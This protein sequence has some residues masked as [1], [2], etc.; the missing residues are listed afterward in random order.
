MHD[1]QK[2]ENTRLVLQRTEGTLHVFQELGVFGFDLGLAVLQRVLPFKNTMSLWAL[3]TDAFI[4][5]VFSYLI[6]M[7]LI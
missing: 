4:R 6:L 5:S 2:H 3:L 7:S 1:T